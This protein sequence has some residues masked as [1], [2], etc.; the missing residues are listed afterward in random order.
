MFGAANAFLVTNI[1]VVSP[2]LKPDTTPPTISFV[3]TA[4]TCIFFIWNG[5][6]FTMPSTSDDHL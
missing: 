4:W 5:A 6:L 1:S 3:L 2:P